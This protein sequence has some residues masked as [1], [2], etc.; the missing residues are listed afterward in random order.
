MTKPAGR[1][2]T[3]ARPKIIRIA[4]PWLIRRFIDR[5]TVFL[6]VAP[7]EVAAV[8]KRFAATPSDWGDGI[9][10]DRGDACTFDLML[11]EFNLKTEPLLRLAAIIRGADTGLP[12]CWRSRSATPACSRTMWLSS[13]P[14]CRSTTRSTAGA[15][16]G[17]KRRTA[18][19]LCRQFAQ[20]QSTTIKG[21]VMSFAIPFD[22]AI[23][24]LGTFVAAFVT[25]LAGAGFA[26]GMVAAGIWLFALTPVQTTTLIVAYALLVQGYST[27]RLRRSIIPSRLPPFVVG[28]AVGIPAGIVVLELASAVHLRTGVGLLLIAFS[29]YNLLRPKMTDLK[30]VGRAGDAGIG[31]LNGR[32]RRH[33]SDLVVRIARLAPRRTSLGIP[34]DRGRNLRHIATGLWRD[35]A[36]YTGDDPAVLDRPA[37]AGRRNCCLAGRST[38]NWMRPHSARSCWFCS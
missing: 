33:Y 12:D 26:F 38:A 22:L 21:T 17:P 27:W 6:Y 7:S 31:F 5:T 29:L 15:A 18:D 24:L 34:A 19:R 10:N 11:E 23:F 1:L 20:N 37:G 13:T 35:G 28:S 9:W 8:S 30:G 32:A 25:G 4:C 3:R 14:R 2:V 36:G 16:T